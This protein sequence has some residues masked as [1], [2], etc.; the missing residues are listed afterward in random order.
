VL[1]ARPTVLLLDEP[2]NHLDADGLG[3][4][5]GFLASDAGAVLVVSH[6]RRFLDNTVTRVLELADGTLRSYTG[7]YS[8]YR[9]E[10]ARERARVAEL[11]EAQDKRRRRLEA[12]IRATRGQALHTEL[13]VSRAAAPRL[14]RYAKKV[15]KKAQARERRLEREMASEDWVQKPRAERALKV[16]LEGDAGARR[17]AA[18]RGVTAGWDGE[19]VLRAVDLTVRGRDRI[20]LTGPNGSG[21]STL[22]ALLAGQLEPTAGSLE[23][24]TP[25]AL[26]PQTPA[27]LPLDVSAA[28]YVRERSGAGEGETRRLLGHFGLEGDAA[29]RPLGRLS[30]GERARVAIASMV[31]SKA[32]LLLLDEPT[33]H[34]DLPSLEVLE[35]ALREYPGAI[36]AASHDRAFLEGLGTTRRLEV[37]D[38]VVVE[39]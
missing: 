2:T 28:A 27:A 16:E 1:L 19:P 9:E 4:L 20:A 18:L 5:E 23:R 33:N 29:L 12:D 15:A 11:Y 14:K 31:A 13:T 24:D 21:K 10:K 17:L 37:R 26:L 7:G 6:D 39:S 35:A 25:H 36:V 3:W 32:P 22:L 30:P 34:L 8:D 38:G